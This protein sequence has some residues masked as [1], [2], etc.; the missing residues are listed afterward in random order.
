M[1][2]IKCPKCKH[3][4]SDTTKK[5]IHCGTRLKEKKQISK[6]IKF[7]LLKSYLKKKINYQFTI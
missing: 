7:Y 4:I 5:C 1:A 6:K 3:E 2:L